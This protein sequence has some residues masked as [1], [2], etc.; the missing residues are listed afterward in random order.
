[1]KTEIYNTKITN[2]YQALDLELSFYSSADE[3]HQE[4]RNQ[5]V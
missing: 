4:T 3:I 2:N 1:M 5:W